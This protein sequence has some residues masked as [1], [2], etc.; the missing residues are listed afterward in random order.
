[1]QDELL[2]E[3]DRRAEI[4]DSRAELLLPLLEHPLRLLLLLLV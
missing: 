3:R 4:Y 2:L 1:L